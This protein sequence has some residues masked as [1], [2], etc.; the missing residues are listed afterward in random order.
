[1]VKCGG[2]FSIGTY[3]VCYENKMVREVS[4]VE[5]LQ[6]DAIIFLLNAAYQLGYSDGSVSR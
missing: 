4:G 5:E 6:L 3:H 2:L 1:M